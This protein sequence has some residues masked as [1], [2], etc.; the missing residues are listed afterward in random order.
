MFRCL[1]FEL[2]DLTSL[3]QVNTHNHFQVDLA[4][5]LIIPSGLS[6][7]PAPLQAPLHMVRLLNSTTLISPYSSI[8]CVVQE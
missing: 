3:R 2:E 4:L 8:E 6:R 7:P 5:C 1:L